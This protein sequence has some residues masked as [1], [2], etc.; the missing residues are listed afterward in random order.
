MPKVSAACLQAVLQVQDQLQELG[1]WPTRVHIPANSPIRQAA[2]AARQVCHLIALHSSRRA[3]TIA[4]AH[5]CL[6]NLR[7]TPC[8]LRGCSNSARPFPP[9]RAC[10]VMLCLSQAGLTQLEPRL[11]SLSCKRPNSIMPSQHANP[12][13]KA[14]WH[15][16]C[17]AG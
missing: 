9:G 13:G 2:L 6:V 4:T 14:C 3:A 17:Y 5:H 1:L 10:G 7:L 11:T 8:L 16:R 15:K 12:A